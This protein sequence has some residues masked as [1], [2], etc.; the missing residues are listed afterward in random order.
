MSTPLAL[1]R[2][3]LVL[4]IASTALAGPASA[5]CLIDGPETMCGG[6]VTLC[7]PD[8]NFEY[9]WSSVNGVI[10][11]G[12]CV[13]VGE[14]GNY[15]LD[16]FDID[17][18]VWIGPCYHYV[19]PGG[20][21]VQCAIT[22]PTSACAGETVTLCGPQGDLSWSWSGP[23]G[24]TASTACVTVSVAGTYRLT[25]RDA[26]GCTQASCEQAVVLDP[27][28]TLES[29][30]RPPA[31]WARACVP[32][33]AAEAVLDPAQRAALAACID[34]HSSLFEWA[35][36]DAGLCATLTPP[37]DGLRNR[38]RRQ[39]A[40]VWANV[41]AGEL[42]TVAGRRAAALDPA[43]AVDLPLYR[44]TVAGWLAQAESELAAME[45]RRMRDPAA[46]EVWRRVVTVGWSINHG[47]G[48]AAVCP[49]VRRA[50]DAGG[51]A[52]LRPTP[53][54]D[55]LARELAEGDLPALAL[56]TVS[57]NPTGGA[58]AVSF[59]L[60]GTTEADVDIAVHDIAGRRVATL[61]RGRLVPGEHVARWDGRDDTGAPARG[62]LYFV[63]ARLGTE[64]VETRVTLLR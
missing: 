7:G 49:M 16:L 54:H 64:R 5:Q 56:G 17:N 40:G 9:Q 24:F 15:A 47:F 22:G 39:L 28:R 51:P 31:F 55:A 8:G 35:N 4:A 41:C 30:P 18:G 38:A 45:G 53:D 19:A 12:A 63:T 43:A 36:P 61:V 29:C 14:P 57:P 3:A 27:C 2:I 59:T 37:G 6:P 42:G 46:R 25:V 21:P 13:T 44:G 34:E 1:R 11:T 32:G 48:L 33:E 58:T 26:A 52:P 60:G 10:G 20:G 62:G 23:G 50:G